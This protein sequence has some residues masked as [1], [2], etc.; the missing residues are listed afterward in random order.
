MGVKL[1]YPVRPVRHKLRRNFKTPAYIYGRGFTLLYFTLPRFPETIVTPAIPT[2][3]M[4][5]IT[6]H[7]AMLIFCEI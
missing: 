5:A 7:T 4:P 6:N 1:F 2:A 3:Q